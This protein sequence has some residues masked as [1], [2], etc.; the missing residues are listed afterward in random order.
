MNGKVNAGKHILKKC[1]KIMQKA[2]AHLSLLITYL[3][4]DGASEVRKQTD[5]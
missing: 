4:C 1:R 5:I 3:P 2:K